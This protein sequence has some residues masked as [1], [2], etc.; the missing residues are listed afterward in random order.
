MCSEKPS[1]THPFKQT[2]TN[3]LKP[4]PQMTSHGLQ[5]PTQNSRMVWGAAREAH[6][7][8]ENL[9]A[10]KT[11][12]K[13]N[14]LNVFSSSRCAQDSLA[15]GSQ[16]LSFCNMGSVGDTFKCPW[17][18]RIGN[19]GYAHDAVGYPVCTE[20]DHSCLWFQIMQRGITS[21]PD[22]L[23]HVLVAR[24]RQMLLRESEWRVIVEFLFGV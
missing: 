9:Q 6:G 7:P 23:F 10:L 21:K 17:C 18:G 8:P 13:Q 19:G 2:K 14:N 16:R 12:Q 11:K 5:I 24:L 1:G 20:G 3:V 4:R 22:Y 15:S